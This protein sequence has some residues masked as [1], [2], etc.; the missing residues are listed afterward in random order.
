DVWFEKNA[1]FDAACAHF[2]DALRDARAGVYDHWTASPRGTLALIILLDQF[3]RNLHRG[4][5]ETYAADARARQVARA[6]VAAGVDQALGPVE[7]SFI[8]LPFEHSEDLA[9]QDE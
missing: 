2:T 9:D 3:S 1:D 8:Y 7:C 6:A 5:P 4:S